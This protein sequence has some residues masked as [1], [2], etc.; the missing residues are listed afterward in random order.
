M[1]IWLQVSMRRG[2][3]AC[4][5]V[6]N[7]AQRYQKQCG[8]EKLLQ[9]GAIRPNFP[10]TKNKSL[11]VSSS[12]LI[13]AAQPIRACEPMRINESVTMEDNRDAAIPA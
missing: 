7:D 2:K 13:S 11:H 9:T 1:F 8:I 12:K 5:P 4:E 3:L 6:L 10:A